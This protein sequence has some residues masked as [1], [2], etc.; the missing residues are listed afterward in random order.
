MQV[1]K[2]DV[3]HTIGLNYITY[4]KDEVSLVELKFKDYLQ[5]TVCNKFIIQ[6]MRQL[7]S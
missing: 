5:K 1:S 6:F 3:C 4:T 2:T 7:V